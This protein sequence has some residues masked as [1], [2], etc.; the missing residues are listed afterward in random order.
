M[1]QTLADIALTFKGRTLTQAERPPTRR[2]KQP[3]R[4]KWGRDEEKII[5]EH[6]PVGGVN[7]CKKKLKASGYIRTKSAIQ[8][9][10]ERMGL[11]VNMPGLLSK[12]SKKNGQGRRHSA[13]RCN[14]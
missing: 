14:S 3:T 2:G 11:C 1:P 5:G 8:S 7:E 9:K 4:T 12:K 6:W 10:A 13:D